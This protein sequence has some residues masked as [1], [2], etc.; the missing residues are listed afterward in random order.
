LPTVPMQGR[1][2]N[3]DGTVEEN[4]GEVA[5]PLTGMKSGNYPAEFIGPRQDLP[6]KQTPAFDRAIF[7]AG[8]HLRAL[9]DAQNVSAGH[10]YW[11]GGPAN[12]STS[13]RF[14]RDQPASEQEL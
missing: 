13:L 7:N 8:E 3:P 11:A 10:K 9:I 5:R 4:L 12:Q 1:Y 14:L 6:F 2:V